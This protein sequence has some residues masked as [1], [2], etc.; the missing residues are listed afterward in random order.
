[1]INSNPL[2]SIIVPI[3]NVENYIDKC[4]NSLVN[5]TYENI[6]ILAVN[7]GTLD[8]SMALVVNYQNQYKN[9]IILNKKNGGLSDARN[10]GIEHANGDFLVFIDSDDYIDYSMIEKLVQ[11]A[12]FNDAEIAVCDMKYIYDNDDTK[13]SSGG[14]FIVDNIKNNPSLFMINNSACNKLFHKKLFDKNSF[15]K[16]IWYED[17]ATIPKCLYE[18]NRIAKV[19]EAL[20]FYYQRSNSIIHTKNQKVFDIYIALNELK[21]YLIKKNDYKRFKRILTRMLVIQGVELTNIRIKSFD[22]SIQ[23]YFQMNHNKSV[24]Y[25]PLW[26]FDLYV[27]SS[28]FKK[29]VAFTLFYLKQFKILE[30]LYKKT[31]QR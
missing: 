15:I 7:D 17:L 11:A 8:N 29:W 10:F 20:Y 9:I 26:Y 30:L 4:F 27:W 23:D 22:G 18:A 13:Y 31:T 14:D 3:Y 6:E 21:S 25:S 24:E 12:L 28:G 16:G 5:Q 19:D 1:M 2:V